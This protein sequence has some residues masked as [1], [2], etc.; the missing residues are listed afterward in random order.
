[1]I[2]YCF[3]FLPIN[4]QK[5]WYWGL[6]GNSDFD[7]LSINHPTSPNYASGKKENCLQ[8]NDIAGATASNWEQST[9]CPISPKDCSHGLSIS[10]WTKIDITDSSEVQLLSTIESNSKALQ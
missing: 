6:D 7:S 2:F 8:G 3:S 10:L 5:S 1:M 4:F 9:D